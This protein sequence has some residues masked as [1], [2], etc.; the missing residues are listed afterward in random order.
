MASS[1]CLYIVHMSRNIAMLYLCTILT[2]Y[3]F[4]SR[5]NRSRDGNRGYWA[6]TAV[7][8]VAEKDENIQVKV[9][10]ANQIREKRRC[11][12]K[13]K[14]IFNNSPFKCFQRYWGLRICLNTFLCSWW[15]CGLKGWKWISK[16]WCAAILS[17]PFLQ[18]KHW[19]LSYW[20]QTNCVQNRIFLLL[21]SFQ[22]TLEEFLRRFRGF[23][24]LSALHQSEQRN[25]LCWLTCI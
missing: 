19:P 25:F 3:V 10:N 15:S 1:W 12:Q 6:L 16:Y 8:T 21:L 18:P 17:V 4:W 9:N 24:I 11:A 23:W 2:V 14:F 22:I 7:F 20:L 13:W 5:L